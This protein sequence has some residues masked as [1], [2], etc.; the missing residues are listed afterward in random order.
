MMRI[1]CE[2]NLTTMCYDR[3]LIAAG[4]EADDNIKDDVFLSRIYDAER[5]FSLF[6]V[7]SI[8]VLATAKLFS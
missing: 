8:Q 4:A 6:K 2:S 5:R 1:G 7:N 3:A